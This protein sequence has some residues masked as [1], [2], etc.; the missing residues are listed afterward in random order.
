MRTGGEIRDAAALGPRAFFRSAGIVAARVAGWCV[1]T[2]L[3]FVLV[4]ALVAAHTPGWF[5]RWTLTTLALFVVPLALIQVPFV[6][7]RRG[8]ATAWSVFVIVALVAGGGR[9]L[10]GA[11]RRHGD[12]FL[13]QRT[14]SSRATCAARVGGIAALLEWFTPPPAMQS[15][16]VSAGSRR[17]PLRAVARTAR[18]PEARRRW[19]AGFIRSPARGAPCRTTSRA[20]SAPCGR[21]RVRRSASSATAASIWRRPLGEPVLRRLRRHRRAR[22]ARRGRR[23]QRAGRYVRIGH[24]DGTRRH[25]ATST[26]TRS[27]RSCAPGAHVLGGE[28]IGTV[29]PHR[30]RRALRARTCTSRCRCA[31]GP[32]SEQLHRSRALPAP[33]GRCPRTRHAPAC[34]RR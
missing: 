17:A 16:D 19:S 8:V 1:A 20:A 14:A 5:G 6:R 28:L 24:K 3:A 31:R 26:S 30:R 21:S 2:A 18:A 32:G 34:R 25:A 13:G 15:H 7:A 4:T 33:L 22:R 29:G 12:W 27:A 23:R 9:S 11:L 10:G